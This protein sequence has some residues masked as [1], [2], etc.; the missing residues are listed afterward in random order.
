MSLYPP[1]TF[2]SVFETEQQKENVLAILKEAGYENG[3]HIIFPEDGNLMIGNSSKL[4]Y[5]NIR[6]SK[7]YGFYILINKTRLIATAEFDKEYEYA[8]QIL[9]KIQREMGQEKV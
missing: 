4:K 1:Y 7:K 3:P 8:K 6:Q 9:S 5:M 2:A